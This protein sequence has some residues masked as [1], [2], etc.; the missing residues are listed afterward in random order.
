MA[1]YRSGLDPWADPLAALQRIQNE[2]NRAFGGTRPRAAPEFPPLN[3]WRGEDGVVVVAE[4]PGVALGDLEIT[5]HQNTLTIRGR[6]EPDVGGADVTFHRR[7]REFGAFARTVTLP[8]H[9]DPD[10][11]RA[12]AHAGILTIELPRPEAEKPKRI[13]IKTA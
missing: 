2:V 1:L 13:E 3:V 10:Q 8:F 7:E 12:G 4:V 9:V 11:V 6:R 5:V